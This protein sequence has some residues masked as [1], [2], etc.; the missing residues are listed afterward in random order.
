[1]L[2]LTL[3]LMPYDLFLELAIAKYT[4]K[5]YRFLT[6]NSSLSPGTPQQSNVLKVWDPAN[7]T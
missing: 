6:T 5:I 1:M 7:E 2:M 3:I 4:D